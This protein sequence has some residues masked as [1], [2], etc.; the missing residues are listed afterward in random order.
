M[1]RT[2]DILTQN[3]ITAVANDD[4]R[5]GRRSKDIFHGPMVEKLLE[6]INSCGV[7]LSVH[8][9]D[10][11]A[12]SLTSLVGGDKL[13][14]LQRQPSKLRNCQ[15]ADFCTTVQKLWTVSTH[16]IVMDS[17]L[18]K[19]GDLLSI[20]YKELSLNTAHTLTQLFFIH[21]IDSVV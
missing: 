14:L 3:L 2:T 17:R 8:D 18:F 12:F 21:A 5:N 4:Y 7:S 16:C 15:P 9:S 13:K 11:K 1:L 10:K 20:I 19:E 6:E